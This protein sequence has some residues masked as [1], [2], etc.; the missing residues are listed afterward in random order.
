MKG[1]AS[2]ST[3]LNVLPMKVSRRELELHEEG[4]AWD[5]DPY[6]SF[7]MGQARRRGAQRIL[8]VLTARS[9]H[10]C[11]TLKAQL[12]G[13]ADLLS[14]TLVVLAEAGELRG[15]CYFGI[16]L[17]GVQIHVPG[18]PTSFVFSARGE[19]FDGTGAGLGPLDGH[20]SRDQLVTLLGGGHHACA[21]AR[22]ATLRVVDE[23]GPR[24]VPLEA[25]PTL[26]L[27]P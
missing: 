3:S 25:L 16:A 18:V 27:R 20:R 2:P 14:E 22:D 4:R 7:L 10:G 11:E 17:G 24:Q 12:E 21:E 6:A 9:C 26:R 23:A 15:P 13:Y 19:S 8:F 1:P 5:L